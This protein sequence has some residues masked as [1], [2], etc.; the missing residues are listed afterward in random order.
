MKLSTQ[1]LYARAIDMGYLSMPV[2]LTA[3]GFVVTQMAARGT[4]AA[5]AIPGWGSGFYF[6]LVESF[7]LL[8]AVSKASGCRTPYTTCVFTL[9]IQAQAAMQVYLAGLLVALSIV[10]LLYAAKWLGTRQD[11]FESGLPDVI[12]GVNRF[13]VLVCPLATV[14]LASWR[15]NALNNS[16][17]QF[18]DIHA[19]ALASGGF[20]A[21]IVVPIENADGMVDGGLA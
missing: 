20:I 12:L 13:W 16:G 6:L 10:G 1:P 18:A 2:T 4:G 3:V 21:S 19:G 15:L 11:A 17:Y 9:R 5:P 7:L 14:W 8:W